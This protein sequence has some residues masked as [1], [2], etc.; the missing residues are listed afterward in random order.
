MFYHENIRKN[1]TSFA[2]S[3]VKSQGVMWNKSINQDIIIVLSLY[4]MLS[5]DSIYVIMNKHSV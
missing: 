2:F 4:F 3:F 5:F 1:P